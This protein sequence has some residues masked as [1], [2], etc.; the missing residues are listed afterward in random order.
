MSESNG[1]EV[2]L[3]LLRKERSR[4]SGWVGAQQ[5]VVKSC[6]QQK[7]LKQMSY[8]LGYEQ[9]ICILTDTETGCRETLSELKVVS[10]TAWKRVNVICMGEVYATGT[11]NT[12]NVTPGHST[13]EGMLCK[14]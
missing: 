9:I 1:M 13:M 3:L 4:S 2:M 10:R 11:L 14:L 7:Q 5:L 8:G 6:A 12:R